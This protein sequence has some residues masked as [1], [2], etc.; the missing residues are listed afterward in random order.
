MIPSAV[1]FDLGKVL[2]DFDYQIL[3]ERFAAYGKLPKTEI[4]RLLDHSPLLFRL[5]TGL[6]TNEEFYREVSI[7]TGFNGTFEEFA[8]TFGD[9][10]SEIPQM[11]AFQSVLRRHGIPTYI[12]SNTNGMAVRHVQRTFPFFANFTGYIYS[13]QHKVMKPNDGLYD[14]V[15]KETGCRGSAIFYLDDKPENVAAGAKRGWQTV[16]HR[17]PAESLAVAKSLG[18]PV[19]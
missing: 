14:V 7:A 6:M 2:V 5:E 18:L 19:S 3:A 8:D 4:R 9:I 11:V 15:E 12:F 1:V 13:Y 17:T 16:V 10:F